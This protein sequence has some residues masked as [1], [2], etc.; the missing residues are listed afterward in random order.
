MLGA[1][2]AVAV[3]GLVAGCASTDSVGSNSAEPAIVTTATTAPIDQI[4]DPSVVTTTMPDADSNEPLEC[5]AQLDRF[6]RIG[7]VLM[8]GIYGPSPANAI[9]PDWRVGGLI[10]M[11]W[12]EGSDVD[13]LAG[14]I[15]TATIPIHLAVD[16]EG[17]SVQRLR[18]L[19]RLPSAREMAALTPEMIV[20][21]ITEHGSRV[22]D[23]GITMVMAPV[24]D[25]APLVGPDTMGSRTF[26]EDP[27]IV[28]RNAQAVIDGWQGAGITPVVKHF[29]GHGSAS[30]DTHDQ[31]ARTPPLDVLL[32]RDLAPYRQLGP[33]VA[34]MVG[35]LEI[36][37]L[38]DGLPASLSPLAIEGL[39]RGELGLDVLVI[40]DALEMG[41]ITS[42]FVL[43]DAA[44]LALGAGADIVLFTDPTSTP[45]IIDSIETA[46]VDGSLP[47][48]RLN[49]AVVRVLV[50]K[51]LE[52]CALTD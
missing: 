29:P 52:P 15:D 44:V 39:L 21:M 47:E 37:D 31:P 28:T 9:D 22:A 43:G 18:S 14:L 48:Q 8:P 33:G 36:P 32:E 41:A 20:E 19:G 12:P 40:T 25:L 23:L 6:T 38:G 34:V 27:L 50:S 17:G 45:D 24:I 49:E 7:Q 11:A 42:R 5:V 13:D 3:I 4:A 46:L 2:L 51:G 30:A 10:L 16:E 26:G 1:A 35:H